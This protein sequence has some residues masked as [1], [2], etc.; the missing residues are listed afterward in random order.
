MVAQYRSRSANDQLNI[1]LKCRIGAQFQLGLLE[2]VHD[3]RMGCALA[4]LGVA[5]GHITDSGQPHHKLLEV[6]DIFSTNILG[7]LSAEVLM[8]LHS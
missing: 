2:K 4:G 1:S 3:L 6:P 5:L 8:P 7:L